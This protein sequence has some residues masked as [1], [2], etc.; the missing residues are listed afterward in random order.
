MIDEACQQVFNGALSW[1]K[2]VSLGGPRAPVPGA[3]IQVMPTGVCQVI[4]TGVCQ[5]IP[6]GGSGQ[7]ATVV[8]QVEKLGGL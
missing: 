2:S 6:T 4:L 1:T 8:S 5:V 3:I 7:G